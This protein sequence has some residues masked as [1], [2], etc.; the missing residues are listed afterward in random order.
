MWLDKYSTSPEG[1]TEPSCSGPTNQSLWPLRKLSLHRSRDASSRNSLT[2]EQSIGRCDRA[3]QYRSKTGRRRR[4]NAATNA[5]LCLSTKCIFTASIISNRYFPSRLQNRTPR[6]NPRG[7][8]L[9]NSSAIHSID[10]RA[11]GGLQFRIAPFVPIRSNSTHLTSE[12]L[13]WSGAACL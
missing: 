1:A 11:V 8:T 12:N 9:T 10:D 4:P 7:P 6:P 5:C 3:F 2:L 13:I